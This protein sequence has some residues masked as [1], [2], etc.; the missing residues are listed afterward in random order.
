MSWEDRHKPNG[1]ECRRKFKQDG[2]IESNGEEKLS[3]GERA[4]IEGTM[5][6]VIEDACA[7]SQYHFLCQCRY[8]I[9]I[10]EL[11]IRKHYSVSVS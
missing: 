1:D 2:R 7:T 8:L 11:R 4:V 5:S 9:K 10:Y 3:M 6:D